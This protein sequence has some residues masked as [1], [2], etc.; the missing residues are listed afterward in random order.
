[1]MVANLEKLGAKPSRLGF[2]CMRLPTLESGKIDRETAGKMVDKARGNGV[3]YFDTAYGYHNGE[4]EL[5]IGEALRKYPRDSF[6][7][8][9]KLPCWLLKT[10][11]DPDRLFTEQL[12]KCGVEYFDFYLLHSLN[13]MHWNNVKNTGALAR[14]Q[15]KK[16][17]GKIRALG[18]S[19]HGDFATFTEVMAAADWDFVQIQVNYLDYVMTDGKTLHDVLCDRGIPCIV[20]EPIRGGFL[21]TLPDVARQELAAVNSE[22]PARWALRWCLDMPNMPVILS[23]MSTMEQVEQNLDTFSA[24][25]PLS[26][27]EK[28]ALTRAA[29][30]MMA[31]KTIPCTGCGYCMDCSFGVDIPKIFTEYNHLKQFGTEFRSTTNYRGL[32][33]EH[34]ADNC[35]RCGACAPLCPQSIDIP[36]RLAEVHETFAAVVL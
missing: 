18:F 29:E 1:M 30:A 24:P 25:A 5:F 9:D 35:T 2:G 11:E 19:F 7:L 28:N 26:P 31:V 4:S 23:G 27:E 6:Y 33:S 22:A 8:A 32:G 17:E 16:R 14:M 10:P 13:A 3:N 34:T 12:E 21:A 20:M 36:T 15:E